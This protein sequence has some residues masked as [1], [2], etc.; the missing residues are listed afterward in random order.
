MN[1]NLNG[2][3]GAERIWVFRKPH[4]KRTN[5]RERWL[6]TG[7]LGFGETPELINWARG[8]IQTLTINTDNCSRL[9]IWEFFCSILIIIRR[10][11]IYIL[12]RILFLRRLVLNNLRLRILPHSPQLIN[13]F[14][15]NESRTVPT[16]IQRVQS[17]TGTRTLLCLYS[18]QS[19]SHKS[20]TIE[21]K[22]GFPEFLSLSM[23]MEIKETF[24]WKEITVAL[25]RVLRYSDGRR[26]GKKRKETV[27]PK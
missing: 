11:K 19:L 22:N 6:E 4:F 23:S 2:S 18:E 5:Q 16:L 13:V 9:G 10:E 26:R 12:S 20:K 8:S 25:Q 24:C 1:R 14:F 27:L 15:F 7:G 17:Y 21:Y 3:I